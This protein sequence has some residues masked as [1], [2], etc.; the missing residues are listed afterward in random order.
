MDFSTKVVRL[1][2]NTQV[3]ARIWDPSGQEKYHTI[4]SLFYR[5]TEGIV[6]VYDVTSLESFQHIKE[7]WLKQI[8]INLTDDLNTIPMILVGNKADTQDF[9]DAKRQVTRQMGIDLAKEMQIG[10]FETSAKDG[11]DVTRMFNNIVA[12]TVH[13]LVKKEQPDDPDDS[14]RKAVNIDDPIP[15]SGGFFSWFCWG[16]FSSSKPSKSSQ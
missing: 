12:A 8:R 14:G 1:A 13:H 9:D 5:Q 6:L 3:E 10:F 16:I 15:D 2:N 11:L 7:V 4:V